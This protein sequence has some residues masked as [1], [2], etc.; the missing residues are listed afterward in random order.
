MDRRKRRRLEGAGWRIGSTTDFLGLIDGEAAL[1][2]VKL[3]LA[4]AVRKQR[5]RR[6]MT[7]QELK[8]RE[9]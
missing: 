2:E 6:G 4:R 8:R 9:E 5:S 7:Q 3:G 1:V